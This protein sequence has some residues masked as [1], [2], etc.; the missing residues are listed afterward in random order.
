MTQA[1]RGSCSL[2]GTD[3]YHGEDGAAVGACHGGW[4]PQAEGAAQPPR[5]EVWW[6]G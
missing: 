5:G 3:M 2:L 4:R 1:G 6:P